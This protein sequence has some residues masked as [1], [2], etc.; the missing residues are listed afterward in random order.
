MPATVFWPITPRPASISAPAYLD[1]RLTFRSDS[2][3]LIQRPR[4]SRP[5]RRYTVSYLGLRTDQ[6]RFLSDWLLSIRFGGLSFGFIHSTA[7]D[8]VT[9]HNLTPIWLTFAAPHA[10]LT[11]F[12][13]W[14]S[15]A[16][17]VTALDWQGFR[18]TRQNATQVSLDGTVSQGPDRTAYVAAYLP[19]ATCLWPEDTT[20]EPV[21]LIGPEQGTL[22]RF[23]QT[24][25][26]EE[27]L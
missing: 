11:G 23:N 16:T 5:R 12:W 18:V 26:I 2:G 25:T 27:L 6:L 10:L 24:F 17:P 19:W 22:G 3:H 8:T 9:M 13:I 1:P 15:R 20:P 4:L 14:L 7:E 21:K